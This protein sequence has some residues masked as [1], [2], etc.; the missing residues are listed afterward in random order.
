MSLVVFCSENRHDT[1]GESC[2]VVYDCMRGRKI[3]GLTCRTW[4]HDPLKLLLA[5][6]GRLCARF[7]LHARRNRKHR[8]QIREAPRGRRKKRPPPVPL[9]LPF[10]RETRP[11]RKYGTRIFGYA[12][13]I[14]Y[15]IR[16]WT[17]WQ[18]NRKATGSETKD[19]SAV[20]KANANVGKPSQFSSGLQIIF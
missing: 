7:P 18:L 6:R 3:H 16:R 9:A 15:Q 19:L 10:P 20:T 13:Y 14:G 5:L 4:V 11:R 2:E 1:R 8:V 12:R 17:S